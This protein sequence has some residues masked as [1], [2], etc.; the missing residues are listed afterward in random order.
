MLAQHVDV[1]HDG[2]NPLV[3]EKLLNPA[4]NLIP[5][6]SVLALTKPLSVLRPPAKIRRVAK[7]DMVGS[8]SNKRN[9]HLGDAFL[10]VAKAPNSR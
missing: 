9:I 10:Y 7:K 1:N 5:P 6:R 4:R 3:A 2:G 8:L